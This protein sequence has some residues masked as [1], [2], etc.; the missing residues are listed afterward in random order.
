MLLLPL[1]YCKTMTMQV[2]EV[3]LLMEEMALLSIQ[4]WDGVHYSNSSKES[5][6]TSGGTT[7]ASLITMEKARREQLLPSL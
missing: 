7:A 5:K 2:V 1:D 6:A 4:A 3:V